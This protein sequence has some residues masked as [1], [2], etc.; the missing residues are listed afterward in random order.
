MLRSGCRTRSSKNQTHWAASC[1]GRR[2]FAFVRKNKRLPTLQICLGFVGQLQPD[3]AV[4]SRN[5]VL[6]RPATF[7]AGVAPA[8]QSSGLLLSADDVNA[9]RSIRCSPHPANSYRKRARRRP[10]TPDL[11][12]WRLRGTTAFAMGQ[13]DLGNAVDAFGFLQ[14]DTHKAVRCSGLPALSDGRSHARHVQR[15]P[16]KNMAVKEIVSA[17]DAYIAELKQARGLIASLFAHSDTR[18]KKPI[19]RNSRGKRKA[20]KLVVQPTVA[21]EVAVQVIPTRTPRQ[22]RR[23][24]KPV[25]QTV[26]A[27]GGPV[28]EGPVVVRSSDLARLRAPSNRGYPTVQKSDTSSDTLGELARDVERLISQRSG[29]VSSGTT[30]SH[31]KSPCS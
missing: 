28:P 31:E 7:E 4:A 12:V 2:P 24:A 30:L 29:S 19:K 18:D 13:N 16:S 10:R 11:V 26:S 3:P 23:P 15:L 22:R 6:N 8:Q 14:L 17:I 1:E 20:E 27:L 9:H 25:S 5:G 21:P